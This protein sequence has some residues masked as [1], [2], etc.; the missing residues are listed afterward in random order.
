MRDRLTASPLLDGAGFA[1]SV[2]AAF[3]ALSK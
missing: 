2:E 3:F 1:G